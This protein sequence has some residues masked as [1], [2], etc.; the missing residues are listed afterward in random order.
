M[1]RILTFTG[2]LVLAAATAHLPSTTFAGNTVVVDDYGDQADWSGVGLERIKDLA[3]FAGVR[4]NQLV[5]YGL[6]VGLDGTGD[7]T[8]QAPFTVQSLKNMLVQ[9]GVTV[10][11][12]INP[13]TKNVAAV[14]VTTD[15]KPFSKPGQRMDVTVSSLGNAKSLRGGTLLMTPLQGADG[16]VYG[17]AQGNLTVSGFG[18][19]GADGSRITVNVPSVGRIPNGATVEREVPT[20]F[21]QGDYLTLNLRRSDFTTADRIAETINS[22]MGDDLARALDG[23]SIR[24]RAPLDPSDRVSFVSVLE[25]LPIEAAAPPARVIINARTG[26][27]VIGEGVTVTPAAISH[28]SLTV[29]ISENPQVSQPGPF[30]AGQT[31]VTPQSNIQVEQEKNRMFLFS[32]GPTLGDIVQAVNDVGAAPGD[33][34]AIL[35]ALREAGALHAELVII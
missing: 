24:V 6:V 1:S 34:V 25:N 32:P 17:M 20:G 16:Q 12:N 27:V 31:V 33:L 30:A 2:A 14:M 11:E 9:L 26:T 3:T 8:T 4:D 15:L 13:Q 21:A 28:G 7:Q 18:A 23:A 5:G 35:E 19:G 10:P 29:T 22:N